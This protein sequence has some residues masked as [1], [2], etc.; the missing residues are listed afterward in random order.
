MWINKFKGCRDARND[1]YESFKS[2]RGKYTQMQ[3]R[4]KKRNGNVTIIDMDMEYKLRLS[5][6]VNEVGLCVRT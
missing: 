2:G 5:R 3:T 1:M 6:C 4:F